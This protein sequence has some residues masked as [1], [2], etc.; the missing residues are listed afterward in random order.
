MFFYL[1]AKWRSSR[2][3]TI[4]N[5]SFFINQE[6]SEIPLNV[7]P[8]KFTFAWL[9]ELVKWSS[10][11]TIHINLRTN[12]KLSSNL[13]NQGT[14]SGEA[15]TALSALYVTNLQYLHIQLSIQYSARLFWELK[16]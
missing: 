3:K 13:C 8:Q 1:D 2:R 15:A 9:Q 11:R 6:F 4:N 10:I 7:G 12:E 5:I 16:Q 14:E